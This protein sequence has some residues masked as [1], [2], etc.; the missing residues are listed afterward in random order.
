MTEQAKIYIVGN[1]SHV[2]FGQE[3]LIIDG[4]SNPYNVAPTKET[5]TN[6]LPVIGKANKPETTGKS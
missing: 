5:E 1:V 2:R 3:G 6:K 4:E